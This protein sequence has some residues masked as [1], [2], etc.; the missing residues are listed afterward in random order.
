MIP[1]MMELQVRPESVISVEW[2]VS[3][4]SNANIQHRISV[5]DRI[6]NRSRGGGAPSSSL[7][8]VGTRACSIA[9]AVVCAYLVGCASPTDDVGFRQ[10]SSI[11]GSTIDWEDVESYSGTLGPSTDFVDR[12]ESAVGQLYDPSTS[13]PVCTGT[14]ISQDLFLTAGHC[15]DFRSFTS[16]QVRFNYQNDPSGTLRTPTYYDVLEEVE[17]ENGGLDY[18]ILRLDGDP[19]DTWGYG[20]PSGFVVDTGVDLTI[21]QH[22]NGLPKKVE[23]GQLDSV[24]S[25]GW[26]AGNYGYESIDTEGGSS[27]SGVLMERTHLIVAVHVT[28]A[29]SGDDSCGPGDPNTGTPMIDIYDESPTIRTAALDAAKLI[30]AGII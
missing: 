10:G 13:D 19:G 15:D 3:H 29:V 14:L 30:A 23:A 28:G 27:G 21:I 12:H 16:L 18:A 9:L 8:S 7:S 25:S 26:L 6:R 11:C 5:T 20:I 2:R 17:D 1:N 24:I 4:T 22:P